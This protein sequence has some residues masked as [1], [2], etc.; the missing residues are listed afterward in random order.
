MFPGHL[1]L[2]ELTLDENGNDLR[3]FYKWEYKL[4]NEQVL[5]AFWD[6]PPRPIYFFPTHTQFKLKPKRNVVKRSVKRSVKRK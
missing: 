6:V 5:T 3:F 1:I 2:I 4:K